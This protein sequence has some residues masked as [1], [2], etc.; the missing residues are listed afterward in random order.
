VTQPRELTLRLGKKARFMG[1]GR[2]VG[3]SHTE[4][5]GTGASKQGNTK[6]EET[7]GQTHNTDAQNR[8]Q[9]LIEKTL[10]KGGGN[11]DWGEKRRIIL[12]ERKHG[13]WL[14]YR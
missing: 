9:K 6:G 11:E 2:L 3:W 5:G 12:H 4:E 14:R 7:P 8:S 13:R 1:L 10:D